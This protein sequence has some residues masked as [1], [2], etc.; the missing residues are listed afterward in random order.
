[1]KKIKN[2]LLVKQIIYGFIAAILM[3]AYIPN[4][5]SAQEVVSRKV[6]LGSSLAGTYTTYDFTF[7]A[8]QSTTIKSVGI[9]ACTTQV[10]A[11]TPAP[12][13]DSSTS[14]LASSSNLGSGGSWTVS[15]ATPTELRML[16]ASNTGAP[17]AGITANFTNVKNPSAAN[18]TF[19]LRITT[20]SDSAWATA[21]D[22]G[23][24]AASTAGQITTTAVVDESLNF[25]I[26]AATVDLG[27]LTKTSTGVGTSTMT[28]GTNGSTGYT[29]SYKGNTL[30]SGT[31]VITAMSSVGASAQNSKQ[32][33]INLKANTV[34]TI[35]TDATGTGSGAA[36]AGYN[37]TNQFKFN[38][39]GDIVASAAATTND[40]V[41]TTS[42]IANIDSATA[43]GHYFTV[44]TYTATANF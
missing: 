29:V 26:A 27:T 15:T 39:A 1:M 7:T 28:V 32:F 31:D 9:A 23:T 10:G 5:V 11:C 30:T 19:Y 35:G 42:Y 4:I 8:A 14:T 3:F 6:V 40:N 18:A 21:V 13:F 44:L 2:Q 17:S 33:G 43:A 16:N 24:I 41:F 22:T 34:P 38:P 37:T 36:T 12:G 20:Y 25:I